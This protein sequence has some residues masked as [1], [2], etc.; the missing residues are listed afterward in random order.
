MT[1]ENEMWPIQLRFG[2]SVVPQELYEI[3]FRSISFYIK[4]LTV[5]EMFTFPSAVL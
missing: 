3:L 2:Q 5:I 1:K 4:V